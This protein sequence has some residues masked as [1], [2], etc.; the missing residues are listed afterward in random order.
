MRILYLTSGFPFPLTSGH[1]R[2]FFLIKELAERHH[3]SLL[4]IVGRGFEAEHV[5]ALEPFTETVET[6]RSRSHSP[7]LA[8]KVARRIAAAVRSDPAVDAMRDAVRRL[9]TLSPFDVVLTGKRTVGALD[10]VPD[11]PVVADL[12]DA[13]SARIRRSIRF[14]NPLRVPFLALELAQIRRAERAL[15]E[16]ADRSLFISSR[17]R[18]DLSVP[19][20]DDSPIVPNGVDLDFWRR[21]SRSLGG[22]AIV[23]TGAMNYRPNTDAALRLVHDILPDVRAEVPDARL[24]VVGKDPTPRLLE[25]GNQPGVEVTGFVDDVRPYLEQATV[26]AAPIRFGAGM[27]NKVLEA[28]AMEVP[29]VAS[30]LAADG[31]RTE[32]GEP[33]PVEVADSVE[34]FVARI[35]AGLRAGA[36]DPTP[37][38]TARTFIERNYT[39][40]ASGRKLEQILEEAVANRGAQLA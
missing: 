20:I 9:N 5:E 23:F 33:P 19:G 18:E 1:L 39:W 6:F 37:F 34:A 36:A 7:S 28:M 31:L 8:G 26:F 15:A 4:S 27:Q 29:V 30:P 35:V 12:C 21:R 38:A 11:L 16:R 32:E 2:H 10:A 17:D 24:V 25:S 40:A 13:T 14:A 22:N 3:V